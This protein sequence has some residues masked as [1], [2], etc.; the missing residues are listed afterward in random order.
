MSLEQITVIG[1][2]SKIM[3]RYVVTTEDGTEYELSAILPWEAVSPDVGS[4]AFALHLGK[5]MQVTGQSDGSTIYGAQ[6][7]DI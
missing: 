7:E 3:D 1:L 4:G 2:I 6:L 5:K